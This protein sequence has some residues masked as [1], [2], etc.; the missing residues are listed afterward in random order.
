[1]AHIIDAT[2]AAEKTASP[3]S[4][5]RVRRVSFVYVVCNKFEKDRCSHTSDRISN[6]DTF[7]ER[8]RERERREREKRE[9]ETTPRNTSSVA[10]R[11]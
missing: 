8:E 1:M 10:S 7:R 6:L 3:I 11:P 5:I 9:R 4:Y 2:S